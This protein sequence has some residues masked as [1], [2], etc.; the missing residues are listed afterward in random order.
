MKLVYYTLALA[1]CISVGCTGSKN[2]SRTAGL[3]AFDFEGH[4]GAR[5]LMPENSIPGM[6]TAIDHGC[7]TLEMDVVISKDKK[8]V[9]SHDTYFSD[10]ITTTP[11]G[12]HLTKKEAGQHLLYQ[13]L[14]EQI[15]KYDVGMKPNPG[16]PDQKKLATYKPLLSD[17]I[18]SSEAYAKSKNRII[19]YN[20]EIKSKEGFDGIQHP[21][22]KE[23][24]DLL[25]AVLKDKG[26]LER[27]I[28]Q[29]FDVR[30]LQYIHQAY[31]AIKLSY[32]VDKTTVSLDDQLTKLG[33]IPDVYSP[34]SSMVTKEIVSQSHKKGMKVI[35]WTVNTVK[36][37]KDIIAMG[38]DGIIS[39][40]PNYFSQLDR[41]RQ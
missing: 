19:R 35:P 3:P 33:F 26:I 1:A 8:V 23:F 20:I 31:P 30:P 9:V 22:S 21:A 5:G 36:E 38:V 24:A 4:R 40:Y 32:L 25:I 2:I 34:K 18:D 39:D 37:M 29:S 11:D 6:K 14:Y 27:T 16:F 28:I 17:L 12:K 10:V 41:T 7:T 15:R 13:M